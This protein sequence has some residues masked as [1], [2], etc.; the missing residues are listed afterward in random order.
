MLVVDVNTDRDQI[1][2]EPSVTLITQVCVPVIHT[3]ATNLSYFHFMCIYVPHKPG[4]TV[5]LVSV[6]EKYKLYMK[7]FVSGN[8]AKQSDKI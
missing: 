1:S 7:C 2:P 6:A 8:T 4:Q 5:A 3:L